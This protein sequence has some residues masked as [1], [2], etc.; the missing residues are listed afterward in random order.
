MLPAGRPSSAS[1]SSSGTSGIAGGGGV[2]FSSAVNGCGGSGGPNGCGGGG[3]PPRPLIPPFATDHTL[4]PGRLSSFPPPSAP[5]TAGRDG[6]AV[7]GES[8]AAAPRRGA[9]KGSRAAAVGT[10][11][12]PPRAAATERG[13]A[14][15]GSSVGVGGAHGA[16]DPVRGFGSGGGGGGAVGQM[17][18]RTVGAPRSVAFT[19]STLA[20]A[21][22]VTTLG[23]GGD[24]GRSCE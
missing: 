2:V 22:A 6:T 16:N 21:D 5:P 15:V 17:T 14:I 18:A 24:V 7:V 10:N 13:V 8:A 19:P 9:L 4:P 20:L 12:Q 1:S 3:G 11:G 23:S